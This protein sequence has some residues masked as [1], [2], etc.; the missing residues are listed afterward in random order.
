MVEPVNNSQ[1]LHLSGGLKLD[2][3]PCP[4]NTAKKA[5]EA[6]GGSSGLSR[7]RVVCASSIAV[8]QDDQSVIIGHELAG[9]LILE[10]DCHKLRSEP[11]NTESSSLGKN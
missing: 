2:T 6:S 9:F 11:P 3:P 10:R 4:S 8:N 5:S 1:T 7:S